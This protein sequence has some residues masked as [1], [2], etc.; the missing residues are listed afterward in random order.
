MQYKIIDNLLSEELIDEIMIDAKKKK[1]NEGK[2]GNHVN[3]K[4]KIRYDLFINDK[5]LLSKIDNVVYSKLYGMILTELNRNAKYRESWKVGFYSSENHGFYNYHRDDTGNTRYRNVSF[6]LSLCEPD[7]YEGG[8][9]HFKELD[10][11]F[12][13]KKNQCIFFD[14]GVLHG[15]TTITKGSRYVLLGFMFDEEGKILKE[16]ISPQ[17][18][19]FNNH[20]VPILEKEILDYYYTI[21]QNNKIDKDYA[22]YYKKIVWNDN[23]DYYYEDNNSNVLLVSFAGMG[24]KNSI[25][26]FI[27]YNFLRRYKE[28]DKLFVR[29]LKQ[30]YYMTGLKNSTKDLKETV[31]LLKKLISKKKYS[32]IVAIGCSAGG[33]AAILYGI[34]LKFDKVLVFSPQVVLNEKK[35]KIIKDTYNAPNTCK[36]LT[37]LKQYKD[38]VFFHK[39]LDLSNFKPFDIDIEIHYAK[40]SNKG[41]DKNHVDYMSDPRCKVKEY[42]SNNHMLALEL[43]DKGLLGD[44][45]DKLINLDK[46]K[47]HEVFNNKSVQVNIPNNDMLPPIEETIHEIRTNVKSKVNSED[48]AVDLES[49]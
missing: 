35:E 6:S 14:P 24:M 25:P 3:H 5:E 26:T 1:L 34:L 33:F 48:N 22:D 21:N 42:N 11:K 49:F 28:L 8:E 9:I 23:D 12:K 15:V 31:E 44:I 18:R 17:P 41:T 19:D 20:Y 36:W 38:D 10:M 13:L 47:I 37:N 32:R 16:K 43:R 2:V 29:D 39:C 40:R 7:S 4:Q 45:I 46:R 30:R 27:F